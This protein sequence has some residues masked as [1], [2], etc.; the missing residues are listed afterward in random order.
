MTLQLE[1]GFDLADLGADYELDVVE[2]GGNTF[3]ATV[4]GS[5]HFLTVTGAT[6]TGDFRD[7]VTSYTPFLTA[8]QTALNA[9]TG[10]GAYT[11]SFDTSTE[12]V[13]IAHNGVGG[14]S[15]VSLTPTTL[16]R[17]VGHTTVLSGA[18]SHELD[19]VPDYCLKSSHGFWT[20]YDE[21]EVADGI[22]F[23]VE[24]HTG[25]PY[26]MAK[27][28]VATLL[29]LTFPLEPRA[30][31]YTARS[32]ASQPWTWQELFRYA[33]SV[34]PLAITDDDLI[35]FCRLTAKGA[36]FAPQH[37]TANYEA[38]FDIPLRMRLLGRGSP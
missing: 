29:D 32:A 37:F 18:L 17:L 12:R 2:T 31:V 35:H 22:A 27:D 15:A 21:R 14:V 16:G 6:A 34:H 30:K 13:T 19:R 28:G 3:T 11:V 5:K 10:G 25:W 4:S 1:A 23:D 36:A 20:D 33:R 8:L 38:Y 24:G 9:G 26:S 7:L